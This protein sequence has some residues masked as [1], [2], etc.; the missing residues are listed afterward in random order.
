VLLVCF[1][2]YLSLTSVGGIF[3]G[4]QWDVLLLETGFVALFIAPWQWRMRRGH[5]APVSRA[6]LFLV[7]ALLFKLMFMSGVV[8]L[9]SGDVSWMNLTALDY[10][11]WTQ[12]LPTVMGWFA[13]KGPEWLKKAGVALT[14][15]IEVVVPFFIWAPRRLRILAAILLLGLQ[16]V[17]A[18][19]GNYC[20]FN[21]LVIALCVLL[22]DD[23]SWAPRRKREVAGSRARWPVLVPATILIATLP[24]NAWLTYT[25]I[26]PQAEWPKPLLAVYGA[27][28]PFRIAN[29]Y[30]LF[31]VMTK[32]RP[33]IEIEGSADGSNWSAYEFKWKP[34]DL[35]RA[36]GWVAPHQPRLDWQMWFAALGTTRQNPWFGSLVVRLLENQ[37]AVT[38]LLAKNPFPNEPPK[39]IR[40]VL[41]DYHF[42]TSAE[43]RET[44]A[45]WKREERGIYLPRVSVR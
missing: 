12:P 1:A 22:F 30:G 29:G 33:E 31:R 23:G 7:K 28:E 16:L 34:G 36:P 38:A 41:Y 32:E 17:I 6:G 45:W 20:F 35:K 42:T 44:G 39:Y 24:I 14:L 43:R 40:A 15:F 21:L 18:L 5:D 26:K 19:T 2:A 25:A 10:H 8:K 9:T 27:I 11:Y 4:F 13:D 37:P 3:F